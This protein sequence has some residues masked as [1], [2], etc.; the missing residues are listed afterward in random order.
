MPTENRE[1]CIGNVRK[2]REYYISISWVVRAV[3]I[4]GVTQ[5]RKEEGE[6]I[7]FTDTRRKCCSCSNT[8]ECEG[9]KARS[10]PV[11]GLRNG[12]EARVTGML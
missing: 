4:G 2:E 12:G 6:G 11:A 8:C 10:E 5:L 1:W 7:R 3:L 9:S